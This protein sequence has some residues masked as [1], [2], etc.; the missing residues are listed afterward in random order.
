MFP[1]NWSDPSILRHLSSPSSATQVAQVAQIA[2]E[3]SP[4]FGAESD[5]VMTCL[6]GMRVALIFHPLKHSSITSTSPVPSRNLHHSLHFNPHP[7]E[8]GQPS[9]E[10]L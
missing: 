10:M 1:S 7:P 6:S 8:G 4:C 2:H 9:L 3:L 5:F